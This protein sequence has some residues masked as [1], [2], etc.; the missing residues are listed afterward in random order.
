MRSAVRAILQRMD[1][2]TLRARA[3]EVVGPDGRPRARL[4]L[5]EDGSLAL[6]LADAG[7]VVRATVGIGPYGCVALGLRDAS[8]VVR[9][10]LGAAPEADGPTSLELLDRGG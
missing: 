1:S 10:L 6:D 4:G 2:D 7:G 5:R 9:S 3:F 8:G